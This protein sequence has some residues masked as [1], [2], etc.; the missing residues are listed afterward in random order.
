[1]SAVS[2]IT[3]DI[4]M[5]P[6]LPVLTSAFLTL[7]SPHISPLN[8]FSQHISSNNIQIKDNLFC[9]SFQLC[10]YEWNLSNE[11]LSTNGELL[12]LQVI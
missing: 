8:D 11:G 5:S 6:A 3:D 1:M 4:E 9:I 7:S 12:N 2:C 10:T